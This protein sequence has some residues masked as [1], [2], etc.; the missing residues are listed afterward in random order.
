MRSA[1]LAK[2][3]TCW[4]SVERTR[5]AEE[6]WVGS[7]AGLHGTGKVRDQQS[8]PPVSGVLVQ[9]VVSPEE[10]RSEVQ[11]LLHEVQGCRTSATCATINRRPPPSHC[12]SG[13]RPRGK[14]THPVEM[15]SEKGRGVGSMGSDAT[16]QNVGEI[17]GRRQNGDVHKPNDDICEVT[18]RKHRISHSTSAY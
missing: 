17:Q 1:R 5:L 8:W 2:F 11:C 7:F 12:C 10:G 14:R 6:A 15:P 9:A 4:R 3:S 18:G 13:R 16:L